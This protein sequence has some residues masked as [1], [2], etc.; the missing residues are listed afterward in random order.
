MVQTETVGI[1]TILNGRTTIPKNVRDWLQLND[2]DKIVFIWEYDINNKGNKINQK[3]RLRGT[4][5][6]I[7]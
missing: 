6:G 2:K 3:I 1:S 5:D 4:K 7:D